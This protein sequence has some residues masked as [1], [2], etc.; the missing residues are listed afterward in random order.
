MNPERV[1]H[2]LRTYP[3]W[4][5][6]GV[7]W[8]ALM[9]L[10]PVVGVDVLPAFAAPA[11]QQPAAATETVPPPPATETAVPAPT[12]P[13]SAPAPAPP[14]PP[15]PDT[16]EPQA[17]TETPPPETIPPEELPPGFFDP[18]FDAIPGLPAVDTP[19][20]LMPLLRA[21]SPI[22]THGCTATGLAAIVLAVAAPSVEGVP[23]ERLI[24]YLSPVTSACANFPIPTTH[25]ECEFD[26]PFIIDLGGLAMSPPILGMGI[27]AIEA[28]E[29][30]LVNTYGVAVPRVSGS[31]RDTLNC[32]VVN[33]Q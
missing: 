15:A 6:A 31:L 8:L 10:L 9:V 33:G 21:V 16:T 18:F 30:E 1:V 14:P 28:F 5:A 13:P 26:K 4:Y 11:P 2:H 24:P 23:L 7:T 17:P 22:A 19:E 32:E 27:D 25:T 20:E 3:R 12:A 29:T